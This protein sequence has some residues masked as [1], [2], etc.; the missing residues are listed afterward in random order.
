MKFSWAVVIILFSIKSFA[1]VD[2]KSANYAETYTDL[3][4]PGIGY[5]LRVTR[6]YNSRSIFNGMFGFGWCSDFETKI[7]VTPENAL[8]LTECG[9]GVEINFLPKNFKANSSDSTISKIIAQLKKKRPDLKDSYLKGLA[10]EMEANT[11][12]RE[13]FA[14]R[15]DIKGSVAA[16]TVF[17]ANGKESE[18][19]T[20]NGGSYKRTL[21]DGTYQLFDAKT[22]RL[23][24]MYDK[25]GNYL[26]LAWGKDGLLG[27]ADN[28]GRKLT[29]KLDP[30]SKK[31]ALII[32]PQK[33]T[34]TYK[35]KGDNLEEVKNAKGEVFKY[36]YD[37]LHNLTRINLPDKTY[38]S[39]TYNK[40][41]DWVTSFRNPKGCIE[42]YDYFLGKPDPKSYFKS[43]VV[44]KCGKEITNQSSYEFFHKQR[45][46]GLG[47]Y[48]HRVKTVNNGAVT[49]ITYHPVF[50]KPL[51][52]LENGEKTEYA[53]YSN[54]YVYTKKEPNR[55]LKYE[56]KGKC[57][58]VSRVHTQFIEKVEA[59][60]AKGKAAKRG[61]SAIEKVTRQFYTDFQYDSKKCNLIAAHNSEG[62]KV[63][64]SY[65]ARG[66]IDK[67]VDQTKKPIHIKYENKFGKPAVV[68]RPGLG[69][70]QVQYKA[71]GEILKVDSKEGPEVAV[72]VASIFNNLLDII[73]PATSESPL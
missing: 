26:K 50:G 24:H 2:M 36:D 48:L 45:Q 56:Y 16:G 72:Q 28:M 53:Y 41:K 29:F 11:F 42:S 49:D 60:I 52:I 64:I 71:D 40:D 22:G 37:E 13:E 34:A 3:E 1:V 55:H 20:L 6:T 70:I 15:L 7:D 12:M 18:N 68:S 51:T 27:V 5:D 73:A 10:K 35:T 9:G 54:G 47:L 61:V 69:T 63:R 59:P 19:I 43:T 57:Q 46:D 33:L 44:K 65:D 23:T 21:S 8:K 38:K 67:I 32:G 25:N 14:R 31:V 66:R 4:V 30:T 62:Q 39:L 17:Y 58:K